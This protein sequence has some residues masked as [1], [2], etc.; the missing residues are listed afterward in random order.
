MSKGCQRTYAGADWT[1]RGLVGLVAPIIGYSTRNRLL[2]VSFTERD[3]VVWA[4]VAI[5]LSKISGKA[6]R[7]NITLPERL[8]TIMDQ[9]AVQRGETRSGLIAQATMEFIAAHHELTN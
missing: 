7:V 6:K 1:R 8:L 5:E 2:I 9:Y 3:E 4:L